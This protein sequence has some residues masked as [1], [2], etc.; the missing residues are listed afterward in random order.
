MHTLVYS[1]VI[2]GLFG[3]QIILNT[4]ISGHELPVYQQH[5]Q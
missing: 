1:M 2:F 5:N 4:V 3:L